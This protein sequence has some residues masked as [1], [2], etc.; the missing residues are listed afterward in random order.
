[1][2]ILLERPPTNPQPADER[3]LEAKI[4]AVH[5]LD[6]SSFGHWWQHGSLNDRVAAVLLACGEYG[7]LAR[8]A[9]W[10]ALLSLIPD[11]GKQVQ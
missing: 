10:A 2:A 5:A 4:L 7:A 8:G 6:T 1:M 3:S 11:R 9:V